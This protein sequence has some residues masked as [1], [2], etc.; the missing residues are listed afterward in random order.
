LVEGIA[1][2]RLWLEDLVSG[3]VASTAEIT[4]R[5]RCSERSV[6]MTLALAFLSPSNTKAAVDGRRQRASRRRFS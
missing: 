2:A 3:R 1:K 6:R 4:G 5:E